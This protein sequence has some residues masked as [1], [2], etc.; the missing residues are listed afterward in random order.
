MTQFPA[1]VVSEVGGDAMQ[2]VDA[3][4]LHAFLGVGTAF[5]DWIARRVN[6]YG[7]EDGTDFCSYLSESIGGRPAKE[8]ALS[9]DMAKELSMVENNDRGHEVRRYFIRMERQAKSPAISLNDPKTLRELLLGSVDR[10]MLLEQAIEA[11]KPKTAFFDQFV[12]ADGLYTFQ[13][14]G[15]A[16][17]CHPN[18]F[19]RWLKTKFVFYQGS[20]L[21]P[22]V[23]YRQQGIFETK[24]ELW[25]GK[26]RLRTYV[27]A[28]GLDYL[29]AKLPV[30]IKIGGRA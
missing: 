19:V 30:E 26:A 23:Q 2:T 21:V 1:I 6:E 14:A 24:S 8:Y 29:A 7:F 12:N 27:T 13:N 25:E 17:E 5:R 18:L 16:L 9:L 3:R 4:D 20:A 22:Y 15:R 11:D 28:K 10:V